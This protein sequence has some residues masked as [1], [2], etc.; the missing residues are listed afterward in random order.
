MVVALVLLNPENLLAAAAGRVVI[1][2]QQATECLQL[3]IQSPL[4]E[5]AVV[6]QEATMLPEV[7]VGAH[8]LI[9]FHLLAAAAAVGDKA[10]VRAVRAAAAVMV[11]AAVQERQAKAMTAAVQTPTKAA[12]AAA[13]D[14]LERNQMVAVVLHHPSAALL[15]LMQAAAGAEPAKAIAAARAAAQAQAVGTEGMQQ[16]AQDQAAVAHL[17]ATQD[18]E[19]LALLLFVI[20]SNDGALC[21]IG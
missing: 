7:L 8:H 10:A 20:G 19:L 21:K 16:E 11:L 4:A 13:Q 12:A 2:R 17:K 15:Q 14:L 18:Q 6:A 9:P 1:A 3:L 5:A